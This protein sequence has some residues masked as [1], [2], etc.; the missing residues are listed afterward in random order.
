[1]AEGG[2]EVESLLR[3]VL[4]GAGIPV[5][6]A[7]PDGGLRYANPAFQ[8]LL[9][10]GEVNEPARSVRKMPPIADIFERVSAGEGELRLY[11]SFVVHGRLR[12][13]LGQHRRILD[14]AG[15]F[16]GVVGFYTDVSEQRRA[17][18][19]AVEFEERFTDFARSV[20]DWVWETDANL[21]LS[22]ASLSIAKVL[23]MP[24]QALKGKHLFSFGCFEDEGDEREPVSSLI[25]AH[26]PFRNRRF[27][28]KAT[29]AG[30]TCY[31]QLSGVP[32]FDEAS[33]RFTGYRGTGSDVTQAVQAER[34]RMESRKALEQAHE[35][36]T[37]KSQHLDFALRQAQAADEAKTQFL[38]RMS[39]ELRT[40]LN[41][42]IGF[43][44]AAS[45]R[46]F[47]LLNDRYA[48]YFSNILRAGRHL[49]TLIEDVLDA[50]RIDSGKLRV[51]PRLVAVK[52]VVAGAVAF[53]EL[54]A[55]SKNLAIS[56]AFAPELPLMWAD[57]VRV[58][59]I[60]VNLLDNAIKFT[61]PGG[62]IRVESITRSD[63]T[64]DIV[65]SDTGI[66][67]PHDQLDYVFE[68][69]HQ[70]S[71]GGPQIGGGGLGLGLAISRQLAR[72]MRGDILVESEVGR[73][74]RFTLRLPRTD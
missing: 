68:R 35:E 31:V 30:E 59:Q 24:P 64:V 42:I 43:S 57:P 53:V 25:A 28:V 36:L 21:N 55:A 29:E 56:T 38:A 26:I 22:H 47:G 12:H 65:V 1:V 66:G 73:G 58:Q 27:A 17:E 40:P 33:G 39:H 14:R 37:L 4:M 3:T 11:Q 19:R 74:S 60:L 32:V 45:L 48:D 10:P 23:G 71:D 18:Q 7:S 9:G 8:A 67:I 44:E 13:F 16:V 54:R 61:L 63:G 69:F 52:E 6:V 2:A 46:I 72:L 50:T 15:A 70:V 34:E 20:S 41:A 51:E 49:L 5:Y 62:R